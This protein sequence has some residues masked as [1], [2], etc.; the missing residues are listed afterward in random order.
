MSDERTPALWLGAW[1]AV[2]GAV[3][4]ALTAGGTAGP[5]AAPDRWGEWMAT[6]P[7]VE[8]AFALVRVAA[9][10]VAWYLAAVTVLG[11]TVRLLRA[12]RLAAAT[13]RLTVPS[14]R[15]LLGG[16]GMALGLAGGLAPLAGP[17]VAVA[18]TAVTS[19]PD[20]TAPE[21]TIT[22][23]RLPPAEPQPPAAVAPPPTAVTP[24]SAPEAPTVEPSSWT[25]QPGECFWTIAEQVLSRA[26]GRPAL[27]QEVV[28]YWQKL[29]EAN[30]AAL[31]DP[32][33]PDLVYPGQTFT[34]PAP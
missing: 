4:A 33:N 29:I 3:L 27:D 14:V 23:R 12:P 32:S 13:D 17:A 6:T 8:A 7:P 25:V 21:T 15:R 22:M 10:V 5:P 16:A 34:V 9:L 18:Q 2:L 11:L 28:P 1:L 30:R 31:V 24:P 26:S 19:A 20:A